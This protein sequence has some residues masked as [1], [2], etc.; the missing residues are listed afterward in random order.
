M[1]AASVVDYIDFACFV[2]SERADIEVVGSE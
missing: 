2:L 1:N